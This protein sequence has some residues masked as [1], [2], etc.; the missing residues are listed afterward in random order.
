MRKYLIITAASFVFLSISCKEKTD[1]DDD[2]SAAPANTVTPVT[3]TS[4]AFGDMSETVQVNAV[5]VFLL[6]THVKASANGYLE[7][8]NV[9]L[10]ELVSKGQ[11][12]FVIKTKEAE[13]LG[14]TI[15]MLDSSL[16]FEGK[17]HVKAQ[18]NGYITQ[19]TYTNGNYVQ[20]GEQLAE[21]TDTKSF[22][23][24]LD[25]P[26]ELTPY[27]EKNKTIEL[28]LPDSTTLEG[29]VQSAFPDIDS[30]SQTQRY[31]IKVNASKQIPENLIAK[32]NL[33]KTAKPN[34]V[35]LPKASVLSDETQSEFWIMKMINDSTAIKIP[36]TKGI[37]TKDNI[38][39]ISPQL[40]STDKILLSGNYGLNDTAKV[41]LIK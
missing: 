34:A 28:H 2:D 1:T 32:V 14:N 35:Y 40:L 3:V 16:H 31:I 5:S 24:L 39:I 33:V 7:A 19:L 13:A 11:T 6:K 29:Y 20:D 38:E 8:V 21:I 15:N 4:P 30:V 27:L 17:I 10:G 23:F 36:V 26:Y 22:V 37:E 9:H 18:G 41:R 25:L 12:L